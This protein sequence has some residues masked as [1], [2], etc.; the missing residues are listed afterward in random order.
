[1]K[2]RDGWISSKISKMINAFFFVVYEFFILEDDDLTQ[3][4]L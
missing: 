3:T 1:M 4:S 2:I